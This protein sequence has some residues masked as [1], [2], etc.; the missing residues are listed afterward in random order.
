MRLPANKAGVI[1][2]AVNQRIG[3]KKNYSGFWEVAGIH[4][5]YFFIKWIFMHKLIF[6]F[7][8][9]LIIVCHDSFLNPITYE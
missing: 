6:L 3:A 5:I 1:Q 7:P 2:E 4:F 8:K 9:R